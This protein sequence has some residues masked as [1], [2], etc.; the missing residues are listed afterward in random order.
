M[1]VLKPGREQKGWS[2]EETCTG[3]GNGGGG[4][5]AVLLVEQPDI[6]QTARHSYDGSS[7]YYTTFTCG[8]CG[9]ETDLKKPT[10]FQPPSKKAWLNREDT[11]K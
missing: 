7:E 5:G 3:S 11:E 1:K 4:C 6:Y 8:A 2:T 10:P 9:V